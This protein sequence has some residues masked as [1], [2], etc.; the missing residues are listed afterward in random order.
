MSKTLTL[1]PRMS[2]KTYASAQTT[3]TFVFIVPKS[4]NKIEVGEAVA[5]QFGVT[6]TN[7]RTIVV[8]GKK[9]RSIRLGKYRKNV[10][11]Q[12]ADYKKAFVT[13][14]EGDSIPIFA[15]VEEAEAAEVKAAEKAAKTAKKETK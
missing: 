4:T 14:K 5:A 1:K 6:V 11:G 8:K 13:L 3:N 2:E 7:V 12:R 9:A 10:M 15:A